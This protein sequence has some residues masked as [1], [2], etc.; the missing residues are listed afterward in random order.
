[1]SV[2]PFGMLL[3]FGDASSRCVL[4]AL[5]L[6]QFDT[7]IPCGWGRGFGGRELQFSGLGWRFA[8]QTNNGQ[9]HLRLPMQRQSNSMPF[10]QDSVGM[11]AI[12]DVV[13]FV[14][15][16]GKPLFQQGTGAAAAQAEDRGLGKFRMPHPLGTDQQ[17]GQA[18]MPA[19]L[20][21]TNLTHQAIG[22]RRQRGFLC[23]G[24]SDGVAKLRADDRRPKR[25]H[26]DG[27]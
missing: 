26:E 9:I 1:M 23:N 21:Q 20:Q 19:P 25:A 22:V 4:Q 3:S 7:G 2:R 12:L 16:P 24:P 15:F 13:E 8:L 5:L 18:M 14:N 10:P 11:K 27:P 6:K 17:Q